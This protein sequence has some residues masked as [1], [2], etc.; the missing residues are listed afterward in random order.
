M[1]QIILPTILEF[2]RL[3]NDGFMK[4]KSLAKKVNQVPQ[5]RTFARN[6]KVFQLLTTKHTHTHTHTHTHIYT[7]TKLALTKK[8]F[9]GAGEYMPLKICQL[10]G[11]FAIFAVEQD[12]YVRP[13]NLFLENEILRKLQ[14]LK[15]RRHKNYG[16]ILC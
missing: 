1:K 9:V 10:R 4:E 6:L 8:I 7:H 11:Q 15:W 13:K 5:Y 2:T 16:V 12:Y 14:T 3:V